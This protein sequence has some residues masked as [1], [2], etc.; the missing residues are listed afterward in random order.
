MQPSEI[1]R[2]LEFLRAAE[3]LKNTHRSAWTSGGWPGPKKMVASRARRPLEHGLKHSRLFNN[4]KAVWFP[5]IF[6]AMTS[7][8]A[9]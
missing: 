4:Y 5:M 8:T 7:I 2:V 1:E 9:P 6:A 3:Q